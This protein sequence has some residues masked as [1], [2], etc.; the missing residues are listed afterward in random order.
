MN[1]ALCILLAWHLGTRPMGPAYSGL[2]HFFPSQIRLL[3]Q[4]LLISYIPKYWQTSLYR[5]LVQHLLTI[6][7]FVLF[8]VQYISIMKCANLTYAF[9]VFW[10]KYIYF[11]VRSWYFCPINPFAPQFSHGKQL[12]FFFLFFS[13]CRLVLLPKCHIK[14][15]TENI[16]GMWLFLYWVQCV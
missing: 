10:K 16:V 12:F 2:L 15:H 6:F 14:K 5:F 3:S 13:F 9:V 4:P 7:C 1:T 11:Y 8:A